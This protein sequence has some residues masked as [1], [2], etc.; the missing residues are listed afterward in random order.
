MQKGE[1]DRNSGLK[2]MRNTWTAFSY[3]KLR[4]IPEG[5]NDSTK[6]R[7]LKFSLRNISQGNGLA[8]SSCMTTLERPAAQTRAADDE[9]S[10]AE[11]LPLREVLLGEPSEENG[12][13]D[14]ARR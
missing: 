1:I 9:S 14:Q 11:E 4:Q 8:F 13:G 5:F 6:T 2:S 7:Q 12:L 10:S 3:R